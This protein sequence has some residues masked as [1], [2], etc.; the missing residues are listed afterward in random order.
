MNLPSIMAALRGE[1]VD[2]PSTLKIC[3]KIDEFNCP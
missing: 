1:L 3:E 2:I